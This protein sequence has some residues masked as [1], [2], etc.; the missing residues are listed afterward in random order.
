MPARLSVVL[1]GGLAALAAAAVPAAAFAAPANVTV[2]IEGSNATLVPRTALRTTTTPVIKDGNAAHSCSGTAAAGALEQATAGN[3]SGTWFS[4]FGYS[5][6]QILGEAHVFPAPEYYTL[7]INNRFATEGICGASSELQEGDD[8]LFFV[9][10][11]VFDPATNGCSN[12]PVLPLGLSTP[13]IV[14]PGAP[15]TVTVVE[16][17]A[18]GKPSPAGGATVAGGAAPATAN[19]DGLATVTLAAPGP[20][21]LR[22]TKAGRARSASEAV[23]ATS[24]D[25]GAC[26]SALAGPAANEAACTTDGADGRCG[27]RDRKAPAARIAGVRD[28]QRFARGKGPRRL[29]AA[30]DSDAS[31]LLAVKLRLT[32]TDR[33]RCWYYSGRAERLRRIRCGLTR[34]AWFSVGD[35]ERVDYLLPRALPRGRYVLDVNAI[36]KA[37]NRDDTRRRGANR[38]VFHVG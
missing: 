11:C 12:A 16:Y 24:G 35:R 32:R 19:G 13:R 17:A 1:V 26:G 15:F 4:P 2:R 36:D 6:E 20:A 3:W 23:C 18:D 14:A 7:W 22:A 10:R 9:D 37:Y 29:R 21:V 28:G 25:D 31:G 34:H 30:V 8:V 5:V 33:G 38:I 27:T